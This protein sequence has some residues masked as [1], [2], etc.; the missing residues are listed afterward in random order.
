[1]IPEFRLATDTGGTF[2]DLIV[3]GNRLYKSSTTPDDP[4][5]GI[6]D[7]V[8]VAAADIGI[9]S[10]QL[11]ERTVQF[12]HGTTRA[13]NAVINGE[14]ARTAI[15]L[16]AGHPDILLWREG[17][18]VGTFDFSTPY[19]D[20]YIPRRLTYEVP[21]R[22]GAQGEVVK[23][24]DELAA[25]NLIKQAEAAGVEAV[26]VC[27]LWSII[28]PT[29]EKMLGSLIAANLPGVPFTLS[30]E[31]NPSIREYR[32]ASSAAIDA[33]LKPLMGAYLGSLGERLRGEGLPQDVL[34]VTSAGGVLPSADVG[35]S[36]IHSLAS[37]PAAAPVAGRRFAAGI[38]SL[39]NVI[40]TDAGGTSFDV[41][42]VRKGVIPWTRETRIGRS[43]L[44]P[45]TG[46]PSVD[47][48]SIGA[49]GGSIA[50]V[51][52]GGLLHV[53]PESAGAAPGP[54]CYGKGGVRPT[55][56]DACLVLG[57]LDPQFFLGGA[58]TIH[59]EL[60]RNA[61]ETHVATPLGMSL[62]EAAA[63]IVTLATEHMVNAIEDIA[64]NQGVDPR[65]ASIIVGGGSGGFYGSAILKRLKALH[66]IVPQAAAALS[67]MG[68][69]ISDLTNDF[70]ETVHASTA[71]FPIKKVNETLERLEKRANAFLA[72]VADSSAS[73][74]ITFSVE[75]R[76]PQQMW[77]LEVP[78]PFSRFKGQEDVDA[79]KASFHKVHQDVL[80][81]ADIGSE[82][83]TITWRAR[84]RARLP[85]VNVDSP[86]PIKAQ[87]AEPAGSRRMFFAGDGVVDGKVY[88]DSGLTAG[89]SVQGPA[90][91]ES[92]ATTIVIVPGVAAKR[93]SSGSILL[94]SVA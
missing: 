1:M 39:D 85:E 75:A 90:V 78:L 27:L 43:Y 15:F 6:L 16:T 9:T 40:V 10:R 37:G 89:M 14:T 44:G 59:S 57:Y 7:V 42:L 36:P 32:R 61:V 4:V 77:D 53:G 35:K 11:L 72:A 67:A 70:A 8:A 52:A 73:T 47:V 17:G 3:N 71:H 12:V 33:S 48:K 83:E 94:T 56:T 55:V 69:L 45:M 29:H 49:G 58:M 19:P 23:P 63:A 66:A 21:E 28:N 93:A 30:H 76:Y 86:W 54:A 91:I 26:A 25:I 80:S 60:S 65:Q 88:R 18:R 34:V 50:W 31:L 38:G 64:I 87:S 68:A 20:P 22:I 51:D 41:S 74:D 82:V 2:T 92:S 5:R 84:A 24:L 13:T 81:I 79:L 62:D 46:F